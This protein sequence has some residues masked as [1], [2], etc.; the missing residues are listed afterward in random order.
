MRFVGAFDAVEDTLLP[1]DEATLLAPPD[2]G[3]RR[4]RVCFVSAGSSA[5][6]SLL[7]ADERLLALDSDSGGR[8]PPPLRFVPVVPAVLG[9]FFFANEL[10]APSG[11][12]S[13]VDFSAAGVN[14]GLL[15]CSVGP[16]DGL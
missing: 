13:I 1:P 7:P 5:G 3:G 2:S 14:F 10:L 4:P 15:L 8:P 12:R 16:P 6:V 9:V 11:G